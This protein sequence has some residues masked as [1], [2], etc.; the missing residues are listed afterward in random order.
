MIN[1]GQR[2]REGRERER[3]RETQRC[4][5]REREWGRE[6]ALPLAPGSTPTR[7]CF[8]SLNLAGKQSVA[9]MAKFLG[10]YFVSVTRA[11][12]GLRVRTSP[13]LKVTVG[14]WALCVCTEG[15]QRS[16]PPRRRR[17]DGVVIL[18]DDVLCMCVYTFLCGSLMFNSHLLHNWVSEW[19]F[20]TLMEAAGLEDQLWAGSPGKKAADDTTAAGSDGRPSLSLSLSGS[21]RCFPPCSFPRP[22]LW[23]L[24]AFALWSWWA[25][26]ACLLTA[27]VELRGKRR[28]EGGA[29][30]QK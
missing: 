9:R 15:P 6:W 24:P 10:T 25:S 4:S 19:I 29:E 30:T 11:G 27:G 13:F 18:Y 5:G 22:S 14:T 12:L 28:G 23:A 16:P 20:S 8:C 3:E 17:T 21:T 7:G 1:K 2:A 26:C